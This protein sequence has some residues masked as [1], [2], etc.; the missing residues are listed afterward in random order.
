MLWSCLH[1]IEH[2]HSIYCNESFR[3][4]RSMSVDAPRDAAFERLELVPDASTCR[5]CVD[6]EC[7]DSVSFEQIRFPACRNVAS[8]TCWSRSTE[9]GVVDSGTE[10]RDP[11][12]GRRWIVPPLGWDVNEVVSL[13]IEGL[14]VEAS[15]LFDRTLKYASTWCVDD[16]IALHSVGLHSQA[17]KLRLQTFAYA[18]WSVDEVLMLHEAGLGMTAWKLHLKTLRYVT[19]WNLDEITFMQESGLRL[20]ARS[21]FEHL[22]LYARWSVSDIFALH[23]SGPSRTAAQLF[24]TT[25][26]YAPSCN[27]DDINSLRVVGLKAEAAQLQNHDKC[28]HRS[29]YSRIFE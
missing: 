5:G 12:T 21:L 3:V 16:I 27:R 11:V 20:E 8:G 10:P 29:L 19:S 15:S 28:L 26:K 23:K 22:L 6:G 9:R 13:K 2:E 1:G 18:R 25:L 17:E 4:S 24:G 14:Y 7:E